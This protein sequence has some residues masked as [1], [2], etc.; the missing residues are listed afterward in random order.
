ML[1]W[2]VQCCVDLI[3]SYFG[4]ES[5]S[6]VTFIDQMI[7]WVSIFSFAARA[8]NFILFHW[9]ITHL[10]IQKHPKMS[11]LFYPKFL[12]I[13]KRV[14]EFYPFSEFIVS[15][16]WNCV[17]FG[18]SNYLICEQMKTEWSEQKMIHFSWWDIMEWR[19]ASIGY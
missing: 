17:S 10:L 9:D 1:M 13:N 4:M 7:D 14:Q 8:I 2:W 12:R 6:Q 16:L 19:G 15:L 18:H 3:I 5:H 11:Q